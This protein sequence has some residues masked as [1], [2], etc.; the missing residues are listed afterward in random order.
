VHGRKK[1]FIPSEV[2]I[3]NIS[4]RNA[5]RK[6]VKTDHLMMLIPK[7]GV[8]LVNVLPEHGI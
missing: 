7:Q 4:G 2:M 1:T 3:Y 5:Y 6:K 8:Y